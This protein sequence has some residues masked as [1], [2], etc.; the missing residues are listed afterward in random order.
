MRSALQIFSFFLYSWYI[1]LLGSQPF[2]WI[3]PRALPFAP[4]SPGAE[5]PLQSLFSSHLVPATQEAQRTELGCYNK[6][7]LVLLMLHIYEKN[8]D[9]IDPIPFFTLVILITGYMN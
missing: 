3:A 1:A 4:T 5:T 8:R 7:P 6:P 9:N 2:V